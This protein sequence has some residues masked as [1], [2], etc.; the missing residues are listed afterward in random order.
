MATGPHWLRSNASEWTPRHVGFFDTE[1]Y[2]VTTGDGREELRLRLWVAGIIDRRPTGKTKP[3]VMTAI[4]TTQREL[5]RWVDRSMVGVPN[6]WLYAHNLGFDLTTTRL[7]DQLTRHGWQLGDFRF[8]GRNVAGKLKKRSKTVWL[9]DS[10]SWLPAALAKVGQATGR[11]KQPMPSFDAPLEAWETY[12]TN[13]MLVLADAVLTLMDWWD[14]EQMGHWAKSGPGCGWNAARHMSRDKLFLIKPDLPGLKHDRK[15]VYGGRRDVTR[16]GEVAGGP[17]AMLDFS[18]AYLTT[19]AH[20]RTPKARLAWQPLDLGRVRD[21]ATLGYGSLAEVEVHTASPRYPLR[22]RQGIFYPTGRFRTWLAQPEIDEADQRGDL[23]SVH[24]GYV[25]DT[26]YPLQKFAHWALQT[27]APEARDIPAVVKMMVKQWGRAVPGRFAMRTSRTLWTAPA[28][29][30]GWHLER[31]TSGP[32]HDPAVNFHMAGRQWFSV[33][34]Q[35][36]ENTYPA[37][38]AWVESHVRVRLNRMLDELGEDLWVVCDTDGVTINLEHAPQ[39]LSQ[40]LG[41]RWRSKDPL[42]AA[43][44]VCEVLGEH[45]GPLVPRVK[46]LSE[47]LTV[48]GPQHYSGDTFSRA[49]GRP[50]KPEVDDQGDLHWWSWPKVGWQMEHGDSGGYTRVERAWTEPAVTAHRFVLADGRAVAPAAVLAGSESLLMDWV[51]TPQ[52]LG[53]AYE[54][55]AAQSPAMLGLY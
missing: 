40:R 39:W 44:A 7:P 27:I 43:R 55:A 2:P 47:T 19:L 49:A 5:A 9:V 50:G 18:D 31:G 12:C 41:R 21:L 22:T 15:A 4:G 13:D 25:H 1:T 35:E 14:R 8:A 28:T 34:D 52:P 53:Q 6:M 37:V 26:G 23:G 48:A 32:D 20:L 46:V 11:H 16:I 45:T 3:A 30:P 54:L 38:L 51:F 36:G 17:F 10:T 24:G 33:Q 42:R 29:W